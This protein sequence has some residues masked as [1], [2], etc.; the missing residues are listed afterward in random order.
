MNI[1]Y[2]IASVPF[3]NYVFYMYCPQPTRE[4]SCIKNM[5]HL[6]FTNSFSI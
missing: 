1:D 4:S 5:N 2:E 6:T 3:N